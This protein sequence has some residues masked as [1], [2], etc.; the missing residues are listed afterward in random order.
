MTGG[1]TT[2]IDLSSTAPSS[3]PG[4][5]FTGSGQMVFGLAFNGGRASDN[6]YRI[7]R[8]DPANSTVTQVVFQTGVTTDLVFEDATFPADVI[9]EGTA[10]VTVLL[11]GINTINGSFLVPAGTSLTLDSAAGTGST[12]GSLTVTGTSLDAGIGGDGVSAGT[13]H[14]A[15]N[16]TILGGT[17]TAIG[18]TGG[19]ASSGGAGIGGGAGGGSGNITILGGQVTARGGGGLASVGGGA[20][21]GDGANKNRA[22]LASANIH[23]GGTAVVEA[24]SRGVGMAIGGGSTNAPA[25]IAI[26][27]TASVKAFTALPYNPIGLYN[28]AV[29]PDSAADG[30]PNRGDG[31]VVNALVAGGSP[32]AAGTTLKVFASNDR[33]TPLTTLDMG[34]YQTFGFQIPGTTG[35]VNYYIEV[36]NGSTFKGTIVRADGSDQVYSINAPGGYNAHNANANNARLQAI[37]DPNYRVT[38]KANGGSGPDYVAAGAETGPV[39]APANVTIFS[40]ATAASK[41]I[42]APSNEQVLLGWNTAADGKGTAYSAGQAAAITTNLV[43]YAQWSALTIDLSESV[44]DGGSLAYSIAPSNGLT[45]WQPYSVVFG[46]GAATN[47]GGWLSAQKPQADY[48]TLTFNQPAHG[49]TFHIIQ[50][51]W[52]AGASELPKNDTSVFNRIVISSNVSVTLNVDDIYLRG[53]IV[54]EAGATLTLLL[55]NTSTFGTPDTERSWIWGGVRGGNNS[56]IIIDSATSS[57]SQDGALKVF[58]LFNDYT[59]ITST[60]RV[61]FKGGDTMLEGPDSPG[62]G[63]NAS[64]LDMSGGKLW[65]EGFIAGASGG[66]VTFTGGEFEG[67]CLGADCAGI[68]ANRLSVSGGTVRSLVEGHYGIFATDADIS[69]G[70]VTAQVIHNSLPTAA[71]LGGTNL[72]I[73]GGE[74]T[75]TIRGEGAAISEDVMDISAGTVK[76]TAFSNGSTPGGAGIGG[77]YGRAGGTV[78]ISGGTVTAKGANGAAGIG[79][80]G[81]GGAG[82]TVTINSGTVTATGGTWLKAPTHDG[83]AG[84]GGGGGNA[85]VIGGGAPATVTIDHAAEVVAY[86]WGDLP[87]VHS[88]S[89][90]TAN[91]GDGYFV[92]AKLAS[93]FDHLVDLKVTDLATAKPHQTLTLPTNYQAFAYSTGTTDECTDQ[94][95]AYRESAPEGDVVRAADDGVVYSMIDL[96]DYNPHNSVKDKGWLPVKFRDYF[97]VTEKHVDQ[98]GNPLPAPVVDTTTQVPRQSPAYSKKAPT[99]AGY[100]TL[101]YYIGQAYPPQGDTYV[102]GDT[103]QVSPVQDHLTVFFV[104]TD[105]ATLSVSNKTVGQYANLNKEFSFAINFFEDEQGKVPLTGGTYHFTKTNPNPALNVSGVAHSVDGLVTFALKDG[106]TYRIEDAPAWAYFKVVEGP[107]D[108]YDT[109]FKDS[110]EAVVETGKDTAGNDVGLRLMSL[111]RSFAF[112]NTRVEVPVS[113]VPFNDRIFVGLIVVAAGLAGLMAIVQGGRRGVVPRR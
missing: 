58:G 88:D 67:K 112:T 66:T 61:V 35:K 17:I 70:E 80:G 99:L 107:D 81:G 54:V 10:S 113:G 76:A 106:E 46:P 52:R 86:S 43:L 56:T 27:A 45:G 90:S 32:V 34:G 91:G 18:G 29:P 101:G 38:Y 77:G 79:G 59:A 2:T 47:G 109:A 26:D 57:G 31:F 65:A 87:A 24:Y 74:V 53:E 83:G 111:D 102:P 28:P 37:I 49:K 94:I 1:T 108:N 89:D 15:G 36:W 97:L 84:I 69:G 6:T 93:D 13:G 14:A 98:A 21:I 9:L 51:G 23:I 48:Y 73:R 20:G 75:A 3:L 68:T 104:Y 96:G 103:V 105:I 5:S 40:A 41:G 92:N 100:A 7:T 95:M 42:T 8:S 72:T 39:S 25:N 64:V 50:S 71:G 4:V 85:N 11:A 22:L 12:S 55:N 82:G 33:T 16:V 44:S 110:V 19:S 63:V 78:T 60:G 62:A 30:G